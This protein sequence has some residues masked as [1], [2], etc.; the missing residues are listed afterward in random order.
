MA[1]VAVPALPQTR[2]LS[3]TRIQRERILPMHGE[4]NA[5]IGSRVDPLDVIARSQGQGHLRPVPI[6]RYMK[7]SDAALPKHLLKQPGDYVTARE[8]IASKPELMGSLRRIYRAPG[9]GRIASPCGAW[10]TLELGGGP[11]ELKAVYRGA[12][13]NVMPPLGVVVEAMGSLAQGVW[14]AG[15]E[16][17]GVLKKMVES[18][19][20]ILTEDKID[21]GARGA[22]LLAGAGITEQAFRRAA[23]EQA[24]GI[25][26]GSLAPALRPVVATLGVTVLVTEGFGERP[27]CKPIWELL[28][29]HNGE[30]TSLNYCG[31]RTGAERPEVFIPAISTVGTPL[32]AQPA[33][34]LV[35]QRGAALRVTGGPQAGAIG[36]L[37]ASAPLPRP[38]ESGISAWGADIELTEGKQVFVPWHNLELIG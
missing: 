36:K 19:D 1:D 29:S 25:I 16:G 10:M 26:L 32:D 3:L 24:V 11:L 35:E 13:A 9:T 23:Q 4:I 28:V 8:I 17:Y 27:M 2:V 18:A 7:L 30:E 38:L 6:A 22:I 34:P 20:A 37:A 15:G 31:E 5:T 12:I 14:G 21:V 33:P